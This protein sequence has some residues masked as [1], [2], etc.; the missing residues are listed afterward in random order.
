MNPLLAAALAFA[1]SQVLLTALL[2]FRNREQWSLPE[3][4]YGVFLIAVTGYLLAP[5]FTSSG[6]SLLL[7]AVQTL[8]PG[9]FWL[10]T[11]SLFDDRFRLRAWQLLLV[12]ITT[13]LPTT[14]K[15]FGV[16]KDSLAEAVLIGLPQGLE[17]VLMGL[18]L[19]AVVRF[20][21]DDLVQARRDLRGWFCGVIGLYI[22]VLL[23]MRELF[24]AGEAWLDSGQYLSVG[25]MLL[26]TNGVLLEAKAGVFHFRNPL[27]LRRDSE[28][29]APVATAIAAN[30]DPDSQ[31]L[32][33]RLVQ[34]SPAV[35]TEV[36]VELL[37][38]LTELMEEQAIYRQMGLTIGQ[39]AS[40]LQMPEYRL[41]KTINTGLGYRN[42]N[43]FLNTYR[44]REACQRLEDPQQKDIPILT[45][46]LDTGFRSLSSF[47]KAFKESQG[48]TPTEYRQASQ[49]G[50]G[51]VKTCTV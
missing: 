14:G 48:Q 11:A 5:L 31:S 36:P 17:F 32:T 35:E 7:N 22:L 4:L 43:D 23:L 12:A 2:F 37:Q 20:W 42:F 6:M 26:M 19:W 41:R 13:V 29:I 24:F 51:V 16:G 45:I 15:V 38:Q 1:L 27:E 33:G 50:M 44:I 21:R 10:F 18:A 34:S 9:T 30:S 3:R 8:V 25:L 40:Q 28:I 47:N 39:V 49:S 46:A